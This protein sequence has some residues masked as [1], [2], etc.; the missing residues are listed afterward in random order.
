MARQMRIKGIRKMGASDIE[1]QVRGQELSKLF[2]VAT[3]V[4]KVAKSSPRLTNVQLGMDLSKPELIVRIDR[5]RAEKMGVGVRD[6]ATTLKALLH[7][8]VATR[9]QDGEEQYDIRIRIPE[10]KLRSKRDVEELVISGSEGRRYRLRDIATVTRGVGPVEIVREDQVKQVIV[11]ADASEVSVGEAL[12]EVRGEL[13]RLD[14]PAGYE[15][16]YGGKARLLE[17]LTET[18]LSI[19]V[20]AVFLA[21]IVLAVQFNSARYPLLILSC[22][23]VSAAGMIFALSLTDLAL[24]ATVLV[25]VLVV[26]AGRSTTVCCSSPWP[27]SSEPGRGCR[28]G[29]GGPRGGAPSFPPR[30]M[31][32]ATTIAGLSPLALNVGAGGDMLQPMAVGAIGGLLLEI[33]VAL[34]LMPC[35]YTMGSR[36]SIKTTNPRSEAS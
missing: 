3:K 19:L 1:V 26:V 11:L 8:V 30:V 6:V 35:L 33:P 7:G 13:G 36:T 25:G 4:V 22:I 28:A 12:A 17:D 10:E 31:T 23:P 5:A 27:T 14:L 15:I 34:F 32:T 20:L 18:T 9:Y 16:G 2:D 24:G 21:A 29:R